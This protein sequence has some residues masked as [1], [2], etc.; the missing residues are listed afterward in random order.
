MVDVG[1]Y[2]ALGVQSPQINT[3]QNFQQAQSTAINQAG[4]KQQQEAAAFQQIAEMGLGVMGSDIDG[5]VDP[6]SFQQML[7]LLG[8]NPLAPKLKEHPELLRTITKSS[9]NVL[10]YAQDAEKFELAKKQFAIDMQNAETAAKKA[11]FVEVSPGATLHDVTGGAS[12]FTAPQTRQLTGTPAEYQIYVDQMKAAGKEPLGILEYQQALK[13][14]GVSV[15]G[16]D[17][18]MIQIGGAAIKAPVAYD[19]EDAKAR[20]KQGME[21]TTAAN[22][23][24]D[25]IAKL[26]KM[27]ELLANDKVYTGIGADQVQALQRFAVTLGADPAGIKDTE[28]FNALTKAAVLDKMGGSLGTGVS[29][30]DRDYIDGQVPSLA[31]TKAG[32]LQLIDITE[33]IAQRQVDIAKQMN[34][35]KKAHD[36]RLTYEWDQTLA[37]W[38]E[39]HPMFEKEAATGD[40]ADPSTLSDDELLKAIGL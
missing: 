1:Q 31:N 16:P 27:K 21:I 9:L 7:G 25:Q 24:R 39:A 23:A 11:R 26:G 33:K 34:E 13:G 20:V 35:F 32:N 14:N 29:N 19:V 36:G 22:A 10:K 18:S 2:V 6:E 30:A 37:D 8:E 4:A 5:E 28:S 12:D 40:I 38:A 17:G 3:M 15:M